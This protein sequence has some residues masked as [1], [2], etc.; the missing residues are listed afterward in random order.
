[1]TEIPY[2]SFGNLIRNPVAY[3]NLHP[4]ETI[5]RRPAERFTATLTL[6]KSIRVGGATYVTWIDEEGHLF[7]MF[8]ADLM[9]VLKTQD[10]AK[11]VVT[12]EWM[13]V[14]RGPNFGLQLYVDHEA[15]RAKYAKTEA[16][17]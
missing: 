8:L 3:S 4:E 7:P 1:M 16:K 15:R 5:H 10:L 6:G 9:V 11:G 17:N 2:D 13:P 12:A 14:G